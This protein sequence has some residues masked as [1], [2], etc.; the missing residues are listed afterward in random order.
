MA[1]RPAQGVRD[2]NIKKKAKV[3]SIITQMQTLYSLN[4]Y[5]SP[6]EVIA[7]QLQA[8]DS[9][10]KQ[11]LLSLCEKSF[12]RVDLR[13]LESI[14]VATAK[15]LV[16]LVPDSLDVIKKW[17]NMKSGKYVYEVHFSLF[18]FLGHIPELPNGKEVA[19]QMLSLI[20]H[21]LLQ[22]TSKTAYAAWMAGDLLGD[23]WQL[24]EAIS[25]LVKTAKGA[26]FVA[27]RKGALHGLAHVLDNLEE[28]H[29]PDSI[30]FKKKI[31]ILLQ[32]ISESDR[33]REARKDAQMILENGGCSCRKT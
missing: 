14:R 9:T 11:H 7:D 6:V 3:A 33:S 2:S 21:Y 31:T 19:A 18:C 16:A 23:H 17:I 25:L 22:V 27:G 26:R 29:S 28:I 13:K 10:Q 5:L 15:I 20:E 12:S 1:W 4:P 30:N 8:L 24:K 32:Q